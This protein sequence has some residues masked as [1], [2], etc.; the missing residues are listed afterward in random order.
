MIITSKMNSGFGLADNLKYNEFVFD[1]LTARN[2]LTSEYQISD[3][4]LFLPGKPI[5][6]VAA[7]KILEAQIPFSY[8]VFNETNN[9]FHL[10]EST[11][12]I[13]L[14]V[15]IPVGNYTAD[16]FVVVVGEALT[17]A[18]ESAG[19]SN[20]QYSASYDF[21]TSK[22]T[23][24]T[25]NTTPGF[26]FKIYMKDQTTISDPDNTHPGPYIGYPDGQVF[27]STTSSYTS[28]ESSNS[29]LVLTASSSTIQVITGS[30][31]HTIQLPALNTLT[32]GQYFK[33]YNTSA[34]TVTVTDSSAVTLKL[35]STSTITTY[36]VNGMGNGWISSSETA[37]TSGSI[38]PDSQAI[39][40]APN[41]MKLSGPNYIYLCST[42]LGPLVKLFLPNETYN[43]QQLGANGP[44][45][46]KIPVDVNSGNIIYWK[47]P[48]ASKWFDMDGLQSFPKIDFYCS[49]G[50]N[51]ESIPLKFNGQGFS[52]KMGVLMAD[53]NVSTFVGGGSQNN[54]VTTR[55]WQPGSIF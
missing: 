15:T 4:P 6:N 20:V 17:R 7:V 52:I 2:E 55:S 16:N 21:V 42:F 11:T 3:W 35:Q 40:E 46:A 51:N 39:L 9:T 8:Y 54:R 34:D 27:T 5:N 30:L 1:S 43:S 28:T 53:A 50:T 49:V 10:I 33:V 31:T 18:S 13:P 22:I 45:I 23:F 38:P 47:D 44:E 41:V 37:Y 29:T 26:F 32:P 19:G 24:S 48:D 14:L 12:S 25:L 36:K